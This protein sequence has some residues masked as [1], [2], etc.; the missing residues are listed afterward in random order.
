VISRRGEEGLKE[1][2]HG[3]NSILFIDEIAHNRGPGA[4]E[5]ARS[6]AARHPQADAGIAAEVQTIGATTIDEYRKYAR[7][8]PRGAPIPAIRSMRRECRTTIKLMRGLRDR[9]RPNNKVSYTDPARGRGLPPG[10]R[11]LK[12][13]MPEKATT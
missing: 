12:T 8:T 3:A 11:Y 5:R 9:T 2:S 13:V 6:R 1:D 7:R 4:E 10:G